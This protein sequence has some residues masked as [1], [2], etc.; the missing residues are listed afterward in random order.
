MLTRVRRQP[1]VICSRKKSWHVEWFDARAGKWQ[2]FTQHY[3]RFIAKIEARWLSEFKETADAWEHKE[4]EK[5]GEVRY[6]QGKRDR[7]A[8]KL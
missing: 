3:Y 8:F 4:A 5:T 2:F 1:D 7:R 6:Y